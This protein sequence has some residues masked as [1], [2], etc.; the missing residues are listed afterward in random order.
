M[1]V[2]PQVRVIEVEVEKGYNLSG[3]GGEDDN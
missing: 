1:Y 3:T 2:V